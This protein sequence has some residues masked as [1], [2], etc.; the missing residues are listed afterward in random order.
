M[1]TE[2]MVAAD[3]LAAVLVGGHSRRMGRD[4][5]RLKV[6]G[7]ALAERLLRLVRP[8]V[9]RV[10]LCGDRP[11]LSDLGVE[12]VSDRRPGQGPLAGLEAALQAAQVPWVLLLACDLAALDAATLRLLLAGRAAAQEAGALAVVARGPRGPEPLVA[13]YHQRLE[14]EVTRRLDTGARALHRLIEATRVQWVEV[15]DSRVLVN[16][17]AP[18][19]LEAFEGG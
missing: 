1:A 4:K 11:D 3:V 18:E 7:T 6:G 16:L 2:G 13:L 5:A 10:V 17:N 9:G 12:V 8:L 15:E 19:D 14:P